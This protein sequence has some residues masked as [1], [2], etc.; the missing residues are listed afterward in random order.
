MDFSQP[1]QANRE[2]AA[3]GEEHAFDLQLN[4]ASQGLRQS[5]PYGACGAGTGKAIVAI[6]RAVFL[7]QTPGYPSPPSTTPC[8]MFSAHKTQALDP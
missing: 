8:L 2:R 1:C 6:H 3:D 7:A 5:I 4:P